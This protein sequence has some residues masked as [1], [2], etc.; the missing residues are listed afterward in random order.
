MKLRTLKLVSVM[1][2]NTAVSESCLPIH[3]ASFFI[4]SFLQNAAEVHP[5]SCSV[6]N[7]VLSQGCSGWGENLTSYSHLVPRL[8]KSGALPLFPIHALIAWTRKALSLIFI[9][10]TDHL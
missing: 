10:T 9:S 5:H 7:V 1:T 3:M 2:I 6:G 4:I 8:R